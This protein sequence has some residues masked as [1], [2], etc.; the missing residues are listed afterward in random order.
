[1]SL[2]SFRFLLSGYHRY[3][4][5]IR[6]LINLHPSPHPD[7]NGYIFGQPRPLTYKFSPVP[8]ISFCKHVAACYSDSPRKCSLFV[9]SS[10][11][12][13]FRVTEPLTDC[14]LCNE[15]YSRSR[16]V[17]GI[18]TYLLTHRSFGI[19]LTAALLPSYC[20]LVWT[21]NWQGWTCTNSI[22]QFESG[23]TGLHNVVCCYFFI[24]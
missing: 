16:L 23:H 12:A 15:A 19:S 11:V 17:I 8:T 18:T 20:L 10:Q 2:S 6:L 4:E 24:F 3:Y 14:M 5:H 13:G 7:L 22:L 21:N 9:S 1:M